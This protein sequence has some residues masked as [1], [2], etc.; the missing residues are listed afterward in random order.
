MNDIT[1]FTDGD[2]L[3]E[4]DRARALRDEILLGQV[5]TE[6][7]HGT[8]TA[9]AACAACGNRDLTV[10]DLPERGTVYSETTINVPPEGFEGSYQIAI[11][12]LD[13]ARV[14]ARIDGRVDVGDE[15][16]LSGV[17]E[18]DG[19]PAPVFEPL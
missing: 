3:T 16:V 6:C 13:D 5:C 19:R 4:A 7:G 2:D 8:A 14:T 11:V 17:F 1:E 12:S 18:V 10:V 15:V 9:H